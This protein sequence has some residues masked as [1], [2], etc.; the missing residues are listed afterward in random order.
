MTREELF[1]D[2]VTRHG[3][4]VLRVC[5]AVLGSG[6]DAD[7]AW[8]ETFLAL[9]S[10]WPDMADDTNVEAWLVRV[11]Q[12]KA[13]D[14]TRSQSRQAIPIGTLPERPSRLG[15]PSSDS[16]ALWQAVAALPARQRLAV[17]YHYLGGLPHAETAELIGGNPA[18]ARRAAADGIKRLRQHYREQ[19]THVRR[20]A[21]MNDTTHDEPDRAVLFPVTEGELA[22]LR[23]RLAR[24]ADEQGL[25]DVAYR[26][27]DSPVGRL[28]LAATDK[29]LVRI[30]Y[31]REGFTSV[32]ETLAARLSPRLLQAPKRLDKVVRELEEYFAGARHDFDVSLDYALSTG[33]R[34]V[35]Q[36]HLPS[37]SYGHTATYKQVAELVGHPKAMRAVG[38]ACATNPLPVVVPC[39]RVLRTDGS[40]GG[41]IG[42]LDA[43][44]ALLRLEEAA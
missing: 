10:A 24:R 6:A 34:Q 40:L 11:A 30:A 2:A 16:V 41:Y 9:L 28:L 18:A 37:I 44:T 15:N 33:F 27:L 19:Q 12:R 5:R 35:V 14:V 3:A 32:L 22:D 13:V 8:S 21:S 25:I 42:G 4:T 20:S 36:R 38:T 26:T 23:A 43:K 29:G 17:T 31:E 39:H 7:D 1:E